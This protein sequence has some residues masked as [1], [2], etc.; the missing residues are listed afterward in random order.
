MMVAVGL[1]IFRKLKTRDIKLILHP[2]VEDK[3]RGEAS[4]ELN[5][6][7][8]FPFVWKDQINN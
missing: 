7:Q 1:R 5:H 3:Y 2:V 8:H 4:V 6:S